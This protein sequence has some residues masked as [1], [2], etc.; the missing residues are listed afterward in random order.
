MDFNKKDD[1]S[2]LFSAENP[3]NLYNAFIFDVK[4]TQKLTI[5]LSYYTINIFL[6]YSIHSSSFLNL[7]V[8]CGLP[9]IQGRHL[10]LHHVPKLSLLV[11]N[12]CCHSYFKIEYCTYILF[13]K[14]AFFIIYNTNKGR[15][16][17]V[18]QTRYYIKSSSSSTYRSALLDI[19][20][21]NCRPLSLIFDCDF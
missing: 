3:P 2:Q 18:L 13:I 15:L 11:Y 9:A 8:D 19:G 17:T 16:Y 7:M 4:Q 6:H 21:S 1:I 12:W 14:R 20:L 5:F 10:Q